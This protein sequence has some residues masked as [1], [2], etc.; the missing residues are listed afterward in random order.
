MS[1][2]AIAYPAQVAVTYARPLLGLGALLSL[3]LIF[4]PM[5]LGLVR[6]AILAVKP[7]QSFEQRTIRSRVKGVLM[8]NSMANDFDQSQPNLAAELR[9]LASRG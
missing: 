1:F 8:L 6:A 7:R 9:G 5:L 2:P 3:F 4:K